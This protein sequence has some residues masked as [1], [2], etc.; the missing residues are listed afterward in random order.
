[1]GLEIKNTDLV[2]RKAISQLWKTKKYS[3][4]SI[5]RLDHGFLYLLNGKITYKFNERKVEL[6]PGDIIY[7]PRG[8][9]YEVEFDIENG[10]I[11]DYLINFD[12]IGDKAF[13]DIHEPT[14]ILKDCA[15]ALTN[16]FKDVVNAYNE[17]DNPFLVNSLFYR[18]LYSLQTAT[19][20]ADGNTEQLFFE[21]AARMVAEN[22]DISVEDI[23][24]DLH[25]SRSAFRKKF[26]WH[27]GTSPIKYRNKKR[28]E[29]AK[30]LLEMT[31]M[32][33]KEISDT[34]GFY[35]TAYFYKVFEKTYSITPKGYRETEKP[36]F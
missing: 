1:M 18:C 16:A 12:V 5:A 35:D 31:D 33:I 2:F 7:L 24:K 32:P 19:Q 30:Q 11:E 9:H 6:K 26:I 4:K 28:L 8:C 23:A 20:Y 27:F 17:K 13:A 14:C 36:N 25:I 10:V 22:V 15:G 21:K 29:K 34:L 3:Y